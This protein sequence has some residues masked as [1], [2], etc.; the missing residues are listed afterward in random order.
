MMKKLSARDAGRL[1]KALAKKFRFDCGVMTLG[2]Y[3][4]R[5][6][7]DYRFHYIRKLSRKKRQGSYTRL[8]T[9][10]HEYSLWRTDDQGQ[11]VGIDVP[12]LVYDHAYGH[13]PKKEK[14]QFSS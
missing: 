6:R 8:K 14:E 5:F 13:L 12:K 7:W 9:P 3:L 11:Q 2:Q 1:N 10:A 4:E